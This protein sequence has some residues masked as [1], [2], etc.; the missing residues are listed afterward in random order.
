[1]SQVVDTAN[2]RVTAL[3][4]CAT[5]WM[6]EV[7]QIR[8]PQ[9]V[10]QQDHQAM[11]ARFDHDIQQL[12][13]HTT[14]PEN[15]QRGTDALVRLGGE[16]RELE[17]QYAQSL[18]AMER[19]YAERLNT[20]NKSL[21]YVI[22]DAFG[23]TLSDPWI[24][25]RLR[26]ALVPQESTSETN[27]AGGQHK[28]TAPGAQTD[29]E[30]NPGPGEHTILEA[31][32]VADANPSQ[33]PRPAEMNP[34]IEPTAEPTT[35]ATTGP[36]TE[37]RPPQE[38]PASGEAEIPVSHENPNPEE[39][40]GPEDGLEDRPET[41]PVRQTTL[42]PETSRTRQMNSA[43]DKN[44]TP[45]MKPGPETNSAVEEDLASRMIP[46]TETNTNSEANTSSGTNVMSP[47][48]PNPGTNIPRDQRTQQAK[49]TREPDLATAPRV[50]AGK[51][52]VAK[53]PSQH[54]GSSNDAS[55]A[56]SS[57]N[58][59][60]S[61]DLATNPRT[62]RK[63]PSETTIDQQQQ[64][65]PRHGYL[66]TV[67]AEENTIDFDQVFQD[68]N[69]QIKYIIAQYPALTGE[70]YILACKEHHRHFLKNPISGA[71][72]HLASHVHGLTKEHS[73]AVQ[74][75]GMRVL[76]CTAALAEKNNEVARDAFSKRL[77]IPPG[78]NERARPNPGNRAE[79]DRPLQD[80]DERIRPQES[81]GTSIPKDVV[82]PVVG[83]IY[84]AHYP[85]LRFLYPVLVLPW[86]SFDHFKWKASLLRVTP[87]CY[88]F[89]KKVDRHPRGWAKG[90]EDG[91]P[92]VGQRQYPVI[93]FD[94]RRFPDQSD[95]DWVSVSS[96]KAFDPND[97]NIGHRNSVAAFLQNKDSRLTTEPHASTT[98]YIVISDD[99]DGDDPNT[100]NVV[101]LENSALTNDNKDEK[102]TIGKQ[103]KDS[104][105]STNRDSQADGH[106]RGTEKSFWSGRGNSDN[107]P[108]FSCDPIQREDIARGIESHSTAQMQSLVRKVMNGCPQPSP[109][110]DSARR[111]EA[112]SVAGEAPEKG[113]GG[114]GDPS[115]S[116]PTT[117]V[118][119]QRAGTLA[120]VGQSAPQGS[121][122]RGFAS[123]RVPENEGLAA[124]AAQAVMSTDGQGLAL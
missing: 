121:V 98:Q 39:N 5:R 68:G 57:S 106:Q 82:M 9:D 18:P 54:K 11:R 3:W 78:S 6:H 62:S 19:D 114:P 110:P 50:S 33:E 10:F 101:K 35:E 32:V 26:L 113:Q 88:L 79:G 17:I 122:S 2:A 81:S 118:E 95:V 30:A 104:E 76:N 107:D 83:E 92:L 24:Q 64:K 4:E 123:P 47:N 63:R 7:H 69:A 74:T 109:P 85:R 66:P 102:T 31:P 103:G 99:S 25:D 90:Y 29:P 15:Y 84:A 20:A 94:G 1:M 28:T 43:P 108:G 44:P 105:D 112:S 70:W 46:A 65:H 8:S 12:T 115:S 111:T 60:T 73:L 14:Q 41:N 48:P 77:G 40:P 36:T 117:G 22:L 87:A 37:G 49:E 116:Q 23:D 75:L 27:M 61:S 55:P 97:T 89:D 71:A 51:D 53:P 34:T 16:M 86:A 120:T 96:F 13:Q 38:N 100:G 21:A 56:G 45:Q 72:K 91:G 67:S 52:Q 93:Y 58:H 42:A 119:R 59:R 124:I 80:R